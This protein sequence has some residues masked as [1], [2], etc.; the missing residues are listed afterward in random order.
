[1][2][3][4]ILHIV[5]PQDTKIGVKEFIY[6]FRVET[7]MWHQNSHWRQWLE[8]HLADSYKSQ[9]EWGTTHTNS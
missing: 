7:P 9:T 4:D 3:V 1:M 2:V 6:L 5:F 8:I